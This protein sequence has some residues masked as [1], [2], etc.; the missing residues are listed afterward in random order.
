MSGEAIRYRMLRDF[1]RRDRVLLVLLAAMLVIFFSKSLE[2]SLIGN[3]KA[4]AMIMAPIGIVAAG[5]TLVIITGGVDLSVGSVV[6]LTSVITAYLAAVGL[7]PL[8][9][10]NPWIAAGIALGIA[11]GVGWLHGTLI[12]R[13]GLAPFVVTFGSL[14]LLR[15][16]AQVISNG[17]PINLRGS[18]FDWMWAN[19]FGFIP[20][21]ALL[22]LSL[23]I[24]TGYLLRNS[25][26]GRYAYAIGSNENVARLSGVNVGRTRQIIYA[27]S[28]LLTG[29]AGL[30]LLALIK[31][32]SFN[33][34]QDYELT[35]IAA[36][37]IGGTSL[38]GGSGGVWGTLG[39]ILLMSLVQQGLVLFSA[40]PLWNQ[41]LTGAIIIS[42][43]LIDIQRRRLQ[44]AAALPP[45]PPVPLPPPNTLDQATNRL[46]HLFNERLG[47][48][49]LYLYLPDRETDTLVRTDGTSASALVMEV[50]ASGKPH[51]TNDLRKENPFGI[52]EPD[53]RAAAA[54]PLFWQNRLVGVAE[55]HSTKPGI[56]NPANLETAIQTSST[57]VSS[58]EDY[59]L[60]ESGWLAQQVREALRKL[61]DEVELDHS[62]L[63]EWLLPTHPNRSAA[64][65]QLML[66]AINHLRAE[67]IDPA[68]RTARRYQIL[69]QTYIDQRNADNIIH[70]LGLSRRQYFYDLKEAI[71]GVTHYL[72]SQRRR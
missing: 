50:R 3:I 48:I 6:A 57:L 70:D 1:E 25:R 42:A 37:I 28:G 35:S 26:Y 5:Q 62:A 65:R 22:M 59:W 20:V 16:L 39:G 52:I 24:I 31:G 47:Q 72:F 63:A 40:P 49:N 30:M 44:E 60:L 64:L 8:G 71:D 29:I 67:K 36:V 4:L 13:Y 46:H 21:P 18:T 23:F 15:G 32:G 33:N 2:S 10:F 54:I 12:S 38:K 51:Y 7:G 19:A 11:T 14:S 69:R 55:L 17:S 56:F 68:S 9:T 45:A 43:A 27:A 41:V 53:V 61:N 66:E 34:G 58:I